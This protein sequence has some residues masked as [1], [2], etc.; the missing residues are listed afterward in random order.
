MKK[1]LILLRARAIIN[2]WEFGI[3]SKYKKERAVAGKGYKNFVSSLYV[4]NIVSQAIFS[5][6]SP[7]AVCTLISYLLVRFASSPSWI[8]APLIVVGALVGF[9]SMIKF[10]LTAMT[11]LERLESEHNAKD[12]ANEQ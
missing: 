4:L 2:M 6:A 9:V 8:Y 1:S 12:N 7:I 10:I 11:G 5:L 3:F